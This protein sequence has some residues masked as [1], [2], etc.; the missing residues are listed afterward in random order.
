MSASSPLKLLFSGPKSRNVLI[1]L[2]TAVLE[3]CSPITEVTLL[4]PE[5]AKEAVSDKGIVLDLRVELADGSQ[6]DIEMQSSRRPGFR[7]RAL[8]YW[9]NLF[10]KQLERGTQYAKLKPVILILFADYRELQAKRLHSVFHVLEKHDHQR[11]SEAFELHMVELPK[12]ADPEATR[13]ASPAVQRWAR[14][15]A[16]RSDEERL[17]AAKEDVMVVEA[18][19]LLNELSADESVRKLARDRELALKFYKLELVE[20]REEGREEG[21]AEGEQKGRAEGEQKG[22]ADAI[23]QVI[24]ARGLRLTPAQGQRLRSCTDVAELDRLLRRALSIVAAQELFEDS[25]P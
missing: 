19:K 3:P 11:F 20:A 7:R 6:V 15:L 21:R 4:D 8:Y 10:G 24:T 5:V 13:A 18:N 14:F 23:V 1:A 2:L 25:D 16:A 9:A 12:L 22:R 17:H